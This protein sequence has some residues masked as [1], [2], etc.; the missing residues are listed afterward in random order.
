MK[1]AINSTVKALSHTPQYKMHKYFARR[2]YNVFSNLIEYYSDKG[3]IVLDI[4]CF[5]L[6]CYTTCSFKKKE[7]QK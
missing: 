7:K 6:I 4:F 1:T 3:Q 2:P 5:N